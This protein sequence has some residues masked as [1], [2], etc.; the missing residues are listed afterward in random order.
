M[1]R[2]AKKWALITPIQKSYWETLSDERRETILRDQLMVTALDNPQV[3]GVV[4]DSFSY[5]VF[6]PAELD[7]IKL[8]I[9]IGS[10]NFDPDKWTVVRAEIL[11]I[12][13]EGAYA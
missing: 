6:E 1:L 2:E 12:P 10:R 11:A 8:P 7:G 9:V 4:D 3:A 5:K 13:S